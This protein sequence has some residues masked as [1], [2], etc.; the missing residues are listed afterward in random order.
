MEQSCDDLAVEGDVR[1]EQGKKPM[2]VAAQKGAFGAATREVLEWRPA[3]L[4]CKRANVR[5]PFPGGDKVG[6]QRLETPAGFGHL[7][8]STIEAIAEELVPGSARDKNP[9]KKAKALEFVE[10]EPEPEPVAVDKP[11]MDMFKVIRNCV[12]CRKGPLMCNF[13]GNI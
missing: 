13:V 7:P 6:T 4:L 5:N 11:S 3:P 12:Y 8:K 9:V 2:E 10:P 1:K